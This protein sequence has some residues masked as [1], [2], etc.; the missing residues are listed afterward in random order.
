MENSGNKKYQKDFIYPPISIYQPLPRLN[1]I[2]L[3]YGKNY[4]I[5]H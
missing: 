1:S 3:N 5:S 4:K 2:I